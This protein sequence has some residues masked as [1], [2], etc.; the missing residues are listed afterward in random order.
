M[1][2]CWSELEAFRPFISGFASQPFSMISS[3]KLSRVPDVGGGP[4][5]WIGIAGSEAFTSRQ[6][7]AVFGLP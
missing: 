7:L 4:N 2:L 6:V 1:S 3:A 5:T